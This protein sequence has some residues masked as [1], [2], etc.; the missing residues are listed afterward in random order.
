SLKNAAQENYEVQ[1]ANAG[2]QAAR[3][4]AFGGSRHA[5]LEAMAGRDLQNRL[6]DIDR[7]AV[8]NAQAQFNTGTSQAM[9]GAQGLQGLA[10]ATQQLGAADVNSLLGVGGLQ[11][12]HAQQGLD[13][14]YQ[15]FLEE[16]D[17][18]INRAGQVLGLLS[19]QTGVNQ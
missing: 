9:S 13:I 12:Q 1:M 19:G 3:Q 5:V 15:D 14:A 8:E 16:R 7:T 10:G 18:D 4:G 17:W 11:Q 6:T 2:A